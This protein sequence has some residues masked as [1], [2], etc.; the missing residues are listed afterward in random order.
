MLVN[1]DFMVRH[2]TNPP[3]RIS[4]IASVPDSLRPVVDHQHKS[5]SN[6]NLSKPTKSKRPSPIAG[7]RAGTGNRV[8]GQFHID[9]G[10]PPLAPIAQGNALC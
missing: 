5:H 6:S 9:D 2:R 10:D 8:T 1:L 3:A 7:P 4:W